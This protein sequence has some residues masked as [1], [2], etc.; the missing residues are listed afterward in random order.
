MVQRK[1]A[2]RRGQSNGPSLEAA[3]ALF[4]KDCESAGY[5]CWTDYYPIFILRALQK[6][7]DPEK[8]RIEVYAKS[9]PA[10][11]DPSCFDWSSAIAIRCVGGRSSVN[12]LSRPWKMGWES[13]QWT[14]VKYLH[15]GTTL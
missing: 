8:N 4:H 5:E 11:G 1:F 10:E 14:D 9:V 13:L 7:I 3:V 2:E 6:H 12:T 15:H